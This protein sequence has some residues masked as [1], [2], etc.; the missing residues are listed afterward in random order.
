MWWWGGYRRKSRS[1]TR[2]KPGFGMT[3]LGRGYCGDC[4]CIPGLTPGVVWGEC[5]L[6]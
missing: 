6:F 4:G 3:W 2:L 1:L 5:S